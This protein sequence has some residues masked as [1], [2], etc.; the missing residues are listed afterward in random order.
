MK[1]KIVGTG[2]ALPQ[3]E[4]GNQK[5]TEWVE[6]SDEWIRERTGI[7]ARRISTGETVVSLASEACRKALEMAGRSAQ[8]VKDE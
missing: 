8:E 7:G 5:L 1:M 3:K 2:S 6:T 4:V